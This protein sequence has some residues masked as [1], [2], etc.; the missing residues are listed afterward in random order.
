MCSNAVLY[1]PKKGG[2]KVVT[3]R[4]DVGLQMAMLLNQLEAP[5]QEAAA[6]GPL[7]Y[8]RILVHSVLVL[9]CYPRLE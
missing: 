8:R 2:G 3:C 5:S 9:P 4:S 6:A 7:S 1:E